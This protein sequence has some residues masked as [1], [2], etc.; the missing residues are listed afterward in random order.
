M[1]WFAATAQRTSG[2]QTA[3]GSKSAADSSN[4]TGP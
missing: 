3:S 4:V 2:L 1:D